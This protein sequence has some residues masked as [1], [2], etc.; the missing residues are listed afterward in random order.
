MSCKQISYAVGTLSSILIYN[1]FIVPEVFPIKPYGGY[2][3]ARTLGAGLAGGFGVVLGE[4]VY[5]L[6]IKVKGP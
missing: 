1:V 2:D 6:I 4:L 3:Y 5:R